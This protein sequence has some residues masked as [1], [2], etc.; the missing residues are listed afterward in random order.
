MR[1]V[2]T[3]RLG[4]KRLGMSAR[5][6]LTE[7]EEHDGQSVA[8]E[9]DMVVIP[10]QKKKRG[11]ES[12]STAKRL[13]KEELTRQISEIIRD[14]EN[15][16][17]KRV[18]HVKPIHPFLRLTGFQSLVNNEL[19][20]ISN[21]IRALNDVRSRLEQDLLKL[22]EDELELDDEREPDLRI[23]YSA[24]SLCLSGRCQGADEI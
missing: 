18:G 17:V 9:E 15:L 13:G 7:E 10:S 2:E 5:G 24:C 21:K 11:R 6:L 20:E 1:N 12:L 4:L 16:H 3:P 8:S 23:M 14:K 22:Q 19:A